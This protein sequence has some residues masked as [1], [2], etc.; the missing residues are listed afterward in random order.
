MAQPARKPIHTAVNIPCDIQPGAFPGEYLVT[1]KLG[2]EV[3]SGFVPE[4]Y[5]VFADEQRRSGSGFVKG[6]IVEQTD[7]ATVIQMPGSFFTTAT[8]KASVSPEW[9]RSNLVPA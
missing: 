4:S 7:A 8:G 5:L 1:I 2:D 6:A 3:V 9:A